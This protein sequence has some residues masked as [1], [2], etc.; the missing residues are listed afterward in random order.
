MNSKDVRIGNYVE[1]DNR[2]F[3]I[4]T[5]S[6]EFPTLDTQEFGIGVVDWNNLNPVKINEDWL[7]LLGFEKQGE[8][9]TY[10]SMRLDSDKY[11]DL[12]L[13]SNEEKTCVYLFPYDNFFKFEYVH[14][15]QNIYFD[16]KNKEL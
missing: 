15:I 13:I 4:D 8:I 12:A 14:Q 3:R 16:L 6:D 10:Y 5:I 1:Y 11:C 2:I 9:E 7:R